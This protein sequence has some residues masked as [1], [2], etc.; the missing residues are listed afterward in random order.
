MAPVTAPLFKAD[1]AT[2]TLSEEKDGKIRVNYA[3][4]ED[5]RVLKEGEG[6]CVHRAGR[7]ARVREGRSSGSSKEGGRFV[8]G[9][10]VAP[11]VAP[12]DAGSPRSLSPS[13]V[14][15]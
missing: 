10:R 13:A 1:S 8:K 11:P 9:G 7:R 2:L 12:S 3:G 15:D 4:W 14:E 5:A 6:V